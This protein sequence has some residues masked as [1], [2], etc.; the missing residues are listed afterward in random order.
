MFEILFSPY[1]R[2]GRAGYWGL[3]AANFAMS[4]ITQGMTTTSPPSLI[5]S[6]L[7]LVIS[8]PMMWISFCIIVKRYHDRN[9][10]G[11][12]FLLGLMPL[13]AIG[14]MVY[15]FITT[16]SF[17]AV[18]IGFVLLSVIVAIWQVIELGFLRGDDGD[19]NFG[20]PAG[21]AARLDAL[22]A[23]LSSLA[24]LTPA[25]TAAAPRM[26][27]APAVSRP[28]MASTSGAPVFGRRT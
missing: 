22:E 21:E 7:L 1:G 23:E 27:T 2:I 3:V 5:V 9:K 19:N 6:L 15:V 13:V 20:P 12:W 14:Y 28:T 11:W 24:G 25:A 4:F 10:S 16:L 26:Q 18:S 8:L 17:S